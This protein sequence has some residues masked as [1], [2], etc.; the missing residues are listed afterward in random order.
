[1]NEQQ[2]LDVTYVAPDASIGRVARLSVAVVEG[3]SPPVILLDNESPSLPAWPVGTL[4][5]FGITGSTSASGAAGIYP[6]LP[7]VEQVGVCDGPY[8]GA[9]RI[10]G[11][12]ATGRLEVYHSGQWGTICEDAFAATDATVACRQLGFASGTARTDVAAGTGPIWLDEVACTSSHL[13]VGTCPSA[14]WGTHDCT[15]TEDVGVTCTP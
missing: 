6:V 3:A 11:G 13:G 7:L 8:D 9:V 4:L 1:L 2:V 12:G 14:G 5:R 10:A 15:H